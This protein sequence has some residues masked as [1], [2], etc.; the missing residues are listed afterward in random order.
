[1]D[2]KAGGID[3]QQFTAVLDKANVFQ[4]WIYVKLTPGLRLWFYVL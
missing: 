1:M 2:W 3:A 4:Y